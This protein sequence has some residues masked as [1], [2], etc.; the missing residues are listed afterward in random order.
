[1]QP[2]A[3][4]AVVSGLSSSPM[5]T[6][7]AVG[8]EQT[9][10]PTAYLWEHASPLGDYQWFVFFDGCPHVCQTRTWQPVSLMCCVCAHRIPCRVCGV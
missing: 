5:K 8:F 6:H 1:M 7:Y 3:T 10:H 2:P 9:G 4:L